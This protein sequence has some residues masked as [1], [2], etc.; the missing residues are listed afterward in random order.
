MDQLEIIKERCAKLDLEIK[1]I[2]EKEEKLLQKKKELHEKRKS[3]EAEISKIKV[4]KE[5]EH[6]RKIVDIIR[7][8]LGDITEERLSD[9]R[10]AMKEVSDLQILEIETETDGD[11]VI[12]ERETELKE[13]L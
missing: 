2:E 8:T 1:K 13:I 11:K 4:R 5:I 12:E 6:N 7:E 10:N 9:F 3:Y